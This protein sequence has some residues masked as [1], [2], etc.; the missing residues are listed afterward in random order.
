MHYFPITIAFLLFL[1]LLFIFLIIAI[2]VGVLS[3]AYQR[4]GIDRRYVFSLLILSLLGSYINIPL[5]QLPPEQIVSNSYVDFFGIRHMIPLVKEWPA[6][7]IAVNIGGAVIPAV[8]SLYLALKNKLY[9]QSLVSIAIVTILVYFM[10]HPVRG[11]G[12]VVPTFIPPIAATAVALIFSSKYAPALAYICGTMG[13][14]LGADIL[15]F[16]D[17]HGLG[18]PVASIGGAGTFDGIFV[19]GILAV[20]LASVMTQKKEKTSSEQN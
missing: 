18:A 20:L 11:V 5:F 17:I 2:E 16:G 4:M 14:L 12:I 3:Y 13:T 6:T 15:H 10:A 9:G 19:T 7:I 8:L 1:L